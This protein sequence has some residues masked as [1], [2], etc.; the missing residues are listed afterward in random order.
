MTSKSAIILVK[1]KSK[2][3]SSKFNYLTEM[4]FSKGAN[5]KQ[6]DGWLYTCRIKN[7]FYQELLSDP[8]IIIEE[9]KPLMSCSTT[10]RS[11]W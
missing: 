11:L 5:E 4:G 2:L 8:N 9:S 6:P 10:T 3:D 7:E 1:D